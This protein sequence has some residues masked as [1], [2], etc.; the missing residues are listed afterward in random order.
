M[1]RFVLH[2]SVAFV[3][4]ISGPAHASDG[5]TIKMTTSQ[6]ATCV[7]TTDVA[8]LSFDAATAIYS[9]RVTSLTGDCTYGGNFGVTLTLPQT[10][11]IGVP[12]NV[13][14]SATSAATVCVYGMPTQGMSGWPAGSKACQGSS[15]CAGN[16][17][18]FVTP[19]A[20][21]TYQFSMI[22]TNDT[23]YAETSIAV[24]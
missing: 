14:W 23:G 9:A 6:Q 13:G 17:L 18:Q 4:G 16:H 5:V 24:H 12:F 10:A 22:C 2:A 19:T 20:P 1:K 8:G 3:V 7:A 15:A 21:G 11:T